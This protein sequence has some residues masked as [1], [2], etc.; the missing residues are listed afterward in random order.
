M[1]NKMIVENKGDIVKHKLVVKRVEIN[2]G[3]QENEAEEVKTCRPACLLQCRR[4]FEGRRRTCF[5]FFCCG[6]V[7]LFLFLMGHITCI[8]LYLLAYRVSC[9][10]TKEYLLAV[11]VTALFFLIKKIPLVF[12]A[13]E[14]N[15]TE[16]STHGTDIFVGWLTGGAKLI[17]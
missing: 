4:F 9:K 1:L 10:G 7:G 16:F 12:F 15:C 14:F 13:E 8:P 6:V 11:S 17:C 3:G 5:F 2:N